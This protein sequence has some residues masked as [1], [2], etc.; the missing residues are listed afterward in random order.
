MR[1][2]PFIYG[3]CV[4]AVFLGVILS[5]QAAGLWSTSGKVDSSGNAVLPSAEDVETIK[6]WMTLEQITTVYNVQLAE[7]ISQFDLPAD[8][9]S[10]AAIKDLESDTF[11]TDLLKDWL[12]IFIDSAATQTGED[13]T[14]SADLSGTPIPAS[15]EESQ[16]ERK[17]TGSTTFEDLLDWGVPQDSIERIIGFSLPTPS[18]IIKDFVLEKGLEFSTTKSLLQTEVD[19]TK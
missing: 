9:P 7:I 2:H 11:S 17:V 10:S 5:F 1:I 6:G 4:V 15:V 13:L 8:T 3:I 12:L 18:T 19:K 14:P 16:T